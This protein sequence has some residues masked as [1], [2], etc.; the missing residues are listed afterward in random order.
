MLYF[1]WEIAYSDHDLINNMENVSKD[2]RQ[3]DEDKKMILSM[4]TSKI[5]KPTN[6]QNRALKRRNIH[7]FIK[8][9]LPHEEYQRRVLEIKTV[10]L[11]KYRYSRIFLWLH[12]DIVEA[13]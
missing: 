2:T 5:N 6:E 13:G 4:K 10:R 12:Q 3:K 7:R 1:G 8:Y 11:A 9:I